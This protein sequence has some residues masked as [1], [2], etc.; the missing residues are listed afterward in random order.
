MTSG[1]RLTLEERVHILSKI[2]TSFIGEIATSLRRHKYTVN[3]FLRSVYES[4]REE[5]IQNG[6]PCS[7]A[8][9]TSYEEIYN[10]SAKRML[11][12]DDSVT[13]LGG[14]DA[15]TSAPTRSEN[16]RGSNR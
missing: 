13:I 4:R 10:G 12:G 15:E 5:L 14:A 9:E 1:I 2:P 16:T 8:D 7:I 6:I 3:K 11:I